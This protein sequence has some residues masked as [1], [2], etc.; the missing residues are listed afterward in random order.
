LVDD[1]VWVARAGQS[2]SVTGWT[3]VGEAL[4]KVLQVADE[5]APQILAD[6]D[7]LTRAGLGADDLIPGVR[8]ASPEAVAELVATARYVLI[9]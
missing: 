8:V 5:P 1:G 4:A 2:T 9:F 3:S 6:Q 7:S